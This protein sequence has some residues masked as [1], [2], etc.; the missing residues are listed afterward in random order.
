MKRQ[1]QEIGVRKWFGDDF[2]SMQDELFAVLEGFFGRYGKQFVLSGCNVDGTTIS[3]GIVGLVDG[4]GFHLCRFAGATNVTW[5]VY[6]YPQKT[7]DT[8]LYVDNNVR[9]VAENWDA[10]VSASNP[11]AYFQLAQDG[12]HYRFEDAIQDSSHRLVSDTEKTSWSGQA[13]SALTSIRGGVAANYDTLKKLYDWIN[14]ELSSIDLG[15]VEESILTTI[16]GGVAADYDTLEKLRAWVAAQLTGIDTTPDWNAIENKPEFEG[17]QSLSGTA[18][19]FA[20]KPVRTKTITENTTLSFTNLT[21]NR[22]ITLL[23]S[24]D[25]ALTFPASVKKITG[26]YDGTVSNLI[27][28]LCVN[29]TSGSEEVWCVINQEAAA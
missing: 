3:A 8:R 1:V 11:G 2:I 20:A 7:N 22:V 19:D 4:N 5:P 26:E 24:G 18:I 6:L 15:E 21:A 27:Q 9:N 14:Q 25:Y 23:V 16:R 28:L 12:N 10:I 13:A 29:A 17:A